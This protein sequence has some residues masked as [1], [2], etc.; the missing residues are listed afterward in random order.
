M[1]LVCGNAN[2]K[3]VELVAYVDAGKGVE[4]SLVRIWKLKFSHMMILSLFVAARE[5]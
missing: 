4:V 1:T 2:S 3:L 5:S